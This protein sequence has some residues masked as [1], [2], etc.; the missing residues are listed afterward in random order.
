MFRVRGNLPPNRRNLHW[1]K[2]SCPWTGRACLGS[3]PTD[4]QSWEIDNLE[5]NGSN[6][7]EEDSSSVFTS[8]L[9]WGKLLISLV[10]YL[11]N[12]F[13]TFI[14]LLQQRCRIQFDESDDEGIVDLLEAQPLFHPHHGAIPCGW[15]SSGW[16]FRPCGGGSWDFARHQC[17]WK[18][19]G[20]A[21]RN[22]NCARALHILYHICHIFFIYF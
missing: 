3:E 22:A 13:S 17:Y 15:K 11:E 7:E 4:R 12:G 2:Q 20:H 21:P 10:F 6:Q 19:C 14:F 8:S 9:P 16:V 1:R 18:G 5:M